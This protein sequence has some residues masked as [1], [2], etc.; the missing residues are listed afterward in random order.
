M[1]VAR[2]LEDAWQ[3]GSFAPQSHGFYFGRVHECAGGGESNDRAA[4]SPSPPPRSSSVER[5]V[6]D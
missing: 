2:E 4:L 6:D 5:A 3:G 1:T